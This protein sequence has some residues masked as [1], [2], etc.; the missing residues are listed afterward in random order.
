MQNK[1]RGNRNAAL[2]ERT[3]KHQVGTTAQFR[4]N[5][6][7]IN[8]YSCGVL[9]RDKNMVHQHS[10]DFG[11]LW[12][13]RFVLGM[14]SKR[15][16]VENSPSDHKTW[17]IWCHGRIHID[18]TSIL[19]FLTCSVKR[20]W[21]QLHH[22]HQSDCSKCNGHGAQVSCMK[23]PIVNFAPL[24]CLEKIIYGHGPSSSSVELPLTLSQYLHKNKLESISGIVPYRLYA[25]LNRI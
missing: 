13:S 17:S 7:P 8:L 3:V 12:S 5:G 20:T 4:P 22:V 15:W 24:R 1:I 23:W 14:S 16:F 6:I 21:T 10:W 18:F 25:P 19:H 9:T 11:E 2:C